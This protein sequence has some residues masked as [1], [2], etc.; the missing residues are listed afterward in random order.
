MIEYEDNLDRSANLKNRDNPK[1]VAGRFV[2]GYA[3]W[4]SKNLSA[5][6]AAMQPVPAA[7]IA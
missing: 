7:V 6:I 4:L 3:F 5:S 1:P 2:S